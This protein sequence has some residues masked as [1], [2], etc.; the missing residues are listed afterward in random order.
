MQQII[1]LLSINSTINCAYLELNNTSP[2]HIQ[3]LQHYYITKKN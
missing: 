3:Q 2:P 1:A